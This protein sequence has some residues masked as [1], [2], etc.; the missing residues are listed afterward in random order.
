MHDG[1][2]LIAHSN[3]LV[4]RKNTRHFS[5]KQKN[6]ECSSVA[7]SMTYARVRAIDKVKILNEYEMACVLEP[8]LLLISY[9][10][11]NKTKPNQ[12]NQTTNRKKNSS[13]NRNA[14]I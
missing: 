8:T 2:V 6:L 4:Y 9:D 12:T 7:L 13:K 11:K 5:T 3:T 10:K 1:G 14:K